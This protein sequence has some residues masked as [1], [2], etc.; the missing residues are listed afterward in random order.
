MGFLAIVNAYTMR[1]SL[2]VAI[3]E[4]VAPSNSTQSYDPDACVVEGGDNSTSTV[5]VTSPPKLQLLV[6][7]ASY[8]RIPTDYTTGTRQLK[9]SF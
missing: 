2:S 3:T 4:M 6:I 5:T 9:V 7:Y 8:C 1:V